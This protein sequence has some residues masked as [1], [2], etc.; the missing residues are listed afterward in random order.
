MKNIML[1]TL[2]ALLLMAGGVTMQ[3]QEEKQKSL[4]GSRKVTEAIPLQMP[5]MLSVEDAWLHYDDGVYYTNMYYVPDGIPFSWAVMF[6]SSVLQQ[7]DGFT[8]TRVA[9]Y[10]NEC[11][12]GNLLL[13][14]YYGTEHEPNVLMNEQLVATANWS[15]FCSYELEHPVEIDA[16]RCLWIVFSETN[17]TNYYYPA[18]VSQNNVDPNPNARW[19]QFEQNKWMDVL[20]D[21]EMWYEI[22]WMI[23]AYVTNDPWGVEELMDLT[24]ST[25]YPN[26]GG[27]TL[28]IRTA[29]QKARVEVYDANGRLVHSQAVTENVMAIDATAWAKG[30][31]VWKVYANNKEVENGKWI[32]Q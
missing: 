14:V 13:G 8:L 4:F 31:Y 19:V 6:P 10:E 27:N 22:Q 20:L 24:A 28:N 9:M 26:P 3:A 2:L 23:R 21:N 15:D 29:L 32:K 30:V 12:Y 5:T 17:I 11:N 16:T 18:T 25:A 1:Y 7:Y